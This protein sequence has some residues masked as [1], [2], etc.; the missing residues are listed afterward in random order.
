[1][2]DE[3]KYLSKEGM[4]HLKLLIQ[5]ALQGKVSKDGNK[6]LSTNDYT[7]EE[8][9]KLASL[10][11]Y[12]L[13]TASADTLGGVKVGAGLEINGGVLSATGGG[14]AD[15]VDWGNVQNKPNFSTVATSG[16]YNDLSN[17]PTI[18]TNNNQ[19]T[20]GA[21]YQTA[22]DV[23]STIN[24]K[25]SSVMT[26]K[27]AVANYTDL[28]SNASVG[29]TYN[30]TKSSDYNEAGDNAVWNGTEWDVLSGTVDLSGYLKKTDIVAITNSEIDAIWES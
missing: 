6:V 13:P 27:G 28:P 14:N 23:E 21:G 12:T 18:P 3:K 16:S 5:N 24:S 9:N 4:S 15:S 29:D 19:L 8:K 17:K 11:N 25:I 7:T 2:N 30:I 20:N 1:M 22:S 10:E 26:Y